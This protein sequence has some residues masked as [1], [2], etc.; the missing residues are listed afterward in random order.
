[1]KLCRFKNAEGEVRV[2]L[3]VDESTIAD[4]SA[5]GVESITSLLEDTNSTQRISD[6]AER[7]LPQLALSEV[8]L[9][10]PVEGQE[11][12]AAGV[13]YLRSKKARMEESDFSA[14][15]Y[16]LVY[17]AAR[18]EIFFKSL[19]NKVVGPGEAVGIREDS[20]WNVPEPELTLVI[21]SAKQLVGYTIGNDM[22]SRDIE[23]ENLL[24]LPQA[25]VYDRSCAVGPW[26]VV[27]ANEAEVR[28]WTIGVEIERGGNA[29]FNGETSINNIKRTFDELVDYLC[30]SQTFSKGAMLLTGTGVVSDDDFTL[31]NDDVIRITISGIGTLENPVATV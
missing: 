6:L 18:P 20:K 8:K 25:K 21:N 1:M 11:V 7:D 2:G 22:S 23:G 13:T 24:Y 30:R 16:D 10:T 27:G 19:P 3:A 28:E 15:A 4:L 9:L 14:N 17:E 5:A 26:I 31:A 29:V 12:W